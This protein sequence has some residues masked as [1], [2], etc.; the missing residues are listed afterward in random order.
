LSGEIKVKIEG[1]E[2]THVVAEAISQVETVSQDKVEA[3]SQDQDF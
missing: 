1:L 3:V 2:S